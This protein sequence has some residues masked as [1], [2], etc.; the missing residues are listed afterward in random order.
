MWEKKWV[1]TNSVQEVKKMLRLPHT[2]IIYTVGRNTYET[3]ATSFPVD[4]G[5]MP[6]HVVIPAIDDYLNNV[7]TVM[8][9]TI[10]LIGKE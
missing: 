3:I 6:D 9:Y 1:H 2:G 10:K 8:E 7:D 4:R 5:I